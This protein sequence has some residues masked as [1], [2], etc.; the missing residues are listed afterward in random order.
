MLVRSKIA[1]AVTLAV[2]TAPVFAAETAPAD[3]AAA[4]LGKAC[5]EAP[6][7]SS[8]Q[9]ALTEVIEKCSAFLALSTLTP[10]QR[11]IALEHRGVA[12]RNAG[13]MIA[14]LADLKQAQ[15][16]AKGDAS[17][18]RMLAWTYRTMNFLA[19]AEQALDQ[20]LELDKSFQGYL[21]RCV[22]RQDRG[23][24]AIALQDCEE[25]LVRDK[26]EDG[27][28]FKAYALFKL[29]RH[30]EAVATV[31]DAERSAITSGRLY[32]ILAANL[33]ALGR[34]QDAQRA[35]ETGRKAFPN[36]AALFG[37]R[38]PQQ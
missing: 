1:V 22:V 10:E 8:D 5:G 26:N 20:S 24:F 7:N 19:E 33:R 14:S 27:F 28:Y 6:A 18:L 25:F 35:E 38:L 34:E 37:P 16:L 3:D 30:P 29:K 31:E 13:N 4:V 21:S 17:I 2:L 32:A 15:S 36:D 23:A 12:Y 9:K 11:A